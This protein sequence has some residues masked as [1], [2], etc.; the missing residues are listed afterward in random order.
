MLKRINLLENPVV[1]ESKE[2]FYSLI[3][4][5]IPKENSDGI[6][7]LGEV[8]GVAYGLFITY[9]NGATSV[10][11]FGSE[12][13]SRSNAVNIPYFGVYIFGELHEFDLTDFCY[14]ISPD[15][16]YAYYRALLV[17]EKE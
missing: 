17:K 1:E 12:I 6:V 5:E 13:M 14:P 4:K 15:N 9:Y 8:S 2:A 7:Y 10:L 3:G 11:A 16:Y